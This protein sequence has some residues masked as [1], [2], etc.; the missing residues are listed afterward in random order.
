MIYGFVDPYL[1]GDWDYFD[2]D[3]A[4]NSYETVTAGACSGLGCC[5]GNSLTKLVH[6]SANYSCYLPYYDDPSQF[7]MTV[8]RPPLPPFLSCGGRSQ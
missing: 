6:D 2:F 5:G 8:R 4:G 3:Y 7:Q 1:P